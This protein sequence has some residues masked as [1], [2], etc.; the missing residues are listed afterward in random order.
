MPLV[1]PPTGHRID[2]RSLNNGRALEEFTRV[3]A[4]ARAWTPTSPVTVTEVPGPSRLAPH[5]MALN[6]DIAAPSQRDE[7]HH[8][9]TPLATGRL[10]VLH[11]PIGQDGWEGSWRL[12]TLV[13]AEIDATLAA[14]DLLGEVGWSWLREAWQRHEVK[15]RAAGATVTLVSSDSFGTLSQRCRSVEMEVRASW[16]P[17]NRAGD[18][19]PADLTRHLDAW[20]SLLRA[21]AGLP[22][23]AG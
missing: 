21:V 9:V 19:P 2:I 7:V 11:D 13:R 4:A 8:E 23:I 18:L 6:A 5:S 15:Y 22:P 10:I 12:V 20:C 1:D 3:R 14:E 17:S 16:T